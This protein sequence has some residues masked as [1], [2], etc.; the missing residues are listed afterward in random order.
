MKIFSNLFLN[1]HIHIFN[2]INI[3]KTINSCIDKEI[4]TVKFVKKEN[5]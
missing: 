2:S 1:V 3:I 5:E 4:L